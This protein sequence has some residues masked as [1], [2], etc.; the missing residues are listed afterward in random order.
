MVFIG[1]YKKLSHLTDDPP[2]STSS[3]YVKLK[4]YGYV[5]KFW[6][7]STM[8]PDVARSF[9]MMSTAKEVWDACKETYGN[10]TNIARVY[11]LHGQL[12]SLQ[13]GEKSFQDYYS[14]FRSIITELEIYQPVVPDINTIKQQRNDL[15]VR[16]FLD[17]LP[18]DIR[19]QL[20]GKVFSSG[21][22]PSVATV[23]S[24]FIRTPVLSS[25]PPQ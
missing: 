2:V 14:Q 20:N 10:V 9:L 13:L 11:E 19:N 18:P 4:A 6:M 22:V 24:Q 17:G 16:T 7:T 21:K 25:P 8:E 12:H 5:V 23:Y 1:A 3:T 15:Y